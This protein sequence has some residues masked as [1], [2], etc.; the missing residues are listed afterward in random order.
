MRFS[1]ASTLREAQHA[2][3]R[4]ARDVVYQRRPEPQ[5]CAGVDARRVSR[6]Y[7]LYTLACW[8]RNAHALARREARHKRAAAKAPLF[9]APLATHV[10]VRQMDI[11]D[12]AD[13]D[14]P[15]PPPLSTPPPPLRILAP[16]P[17]RPRQWLTAH[18]Q[19]TWL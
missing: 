12:V 2:Y 18:L 5:M 11:D 16:V 15:M 19:N 17:W 3:M 1:V 14:A 4:M 8:R 10:C 13:V 9:P 6:G 7:I